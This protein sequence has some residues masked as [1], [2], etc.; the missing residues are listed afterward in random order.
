MTTKKVVCVQ[1]F[2]FQAGEKGGDIKTW[3]LIW[4][5]EHTPT[6]DSKPH[7]VTLVETH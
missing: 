5:I 6:S 1:S 2:D 7:L 4:H 3:L